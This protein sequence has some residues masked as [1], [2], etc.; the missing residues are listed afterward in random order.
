[1]IWIDGPGQFSNGVAAGSN[2]ILQNASPCTVYAQTSRIQFLSPTEVLVRLDIG[3][4]N[5][6][7]GLTL[8]FFRA[9]DAG[10]GRTTWAQDFGYTYPVPNAP[11]SALSL[12]SFKACLDGTLQPLPSEC[13]LASSATPYLITQTLWIARSNV[14][15]RGESKTSTILQK[16][17]TDNRDDALFAMTDPIMRIRFGPGIGPF[18]NI[19]IR[20]LTFDGNRTGRETVEPAVFAGLQNAPEASGELEILNVTGS[21][22]SGYPGMK[23]INCRFINSATSA[24]TMH[25]PIN[26]PAAYP[27]GTPT[28]GIVF[29]NNEFTHSLRAPIHISLAG[30]WSPQSILP[31]DGNPLPPGEI[32]IRSTCDVS[33][34]NENKFY[35]DLGTSVVNPAGTLVPAVGS[36]VGLPAEAVNDV[37]VQNNFFENNDTGAFGIT[38]S[39]G[40]VIKNNA[41]LNNMNNGW[42]CGGGVVAILSCG[43]TVTVD[44]NFIWNRDVYGYSS[45][46][47]SLGLNPNLTR[48]DQRAQAS[49]LELWG[50]NISVTNNWIEYFTTEGI[51]ATSVQKL[52]VSGNTIRNASRQFQASGDNSTTVFLEDDKPGIQIANCNQNNVARPV[53]TISILNN[54]VG[55]TNS[56]YQSY[57]IRVRQA[58]CG[59]IPTETMTNVN[60]NSNSGENRQGLACVFGGLQGS[61]PLLSGCNDDVTF[62]YTLNGKFCGTAGCK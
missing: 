11:S 15:I 29:Q 41:M 40:I 47:A 7:N 22:T 54:S 27:N 17:R 23:V 43:R 31:S 50:H 1:M 34:G 61:L 60:I 58:Q 37:L 56:I 5:A 35:T 16:Y 14:I 49:G 42:D 57:G 62:G 6:W 24:V 9:F 12:V 48:S 32:D 13:V 21:T 28:K 10:L 33:S 30:G 55:N 3:F 44:Q 46:C 25:P 53:D 36:S 51:F 39:I 4:S 26:Y 52:T 59:V 19:T 2:Q 18:T 45:R 20:D 38:S 8:N